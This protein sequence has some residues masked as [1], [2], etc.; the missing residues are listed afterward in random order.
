MLQKMDPPPLWGI[1][2]ITVTEGEA[3][4]FNRDERNQAIKDLL[5]KVRSE[6]DAGN[7]Q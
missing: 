3:F 5:E 7:R 4:K 2:L 1:D 6:Y